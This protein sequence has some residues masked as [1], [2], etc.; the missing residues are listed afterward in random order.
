M[1][2]RPEVPWHVAG[3]LGISGSD[4]RVVARHGAAAGNSLEH[5]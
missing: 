1:R 3:R 5:S 4:N 2:A